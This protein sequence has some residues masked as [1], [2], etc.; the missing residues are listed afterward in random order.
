MPPDTESAPAGHVPLSCRWQ[1]PLFVVR[2]SSVPVQSDNTSGC[3]GGCTLPD[4]LWTPGFGDTRCPQSTQRGQDEPWSGGR[5]GEHGSTTTPWCQDP[6]L[7][8]TASP[9]CPSPPEVH[10]CRSVPLASLPSIMLA[11]ITQGTK[12]LA[13]PSR[14]EN[15]FSASRKKMLW[16]TL[17]G[18]M[19][20]YCA[21]H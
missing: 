10:T 5:G 1:Q 15:Q 11:I 6:S 2:S 7:L 8:P 12:P 4:F 16:R 21:Q 20:A 17:A 18:G 13:S 9:G 3:L 14:L 19:N